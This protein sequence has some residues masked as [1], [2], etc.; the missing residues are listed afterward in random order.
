MQTIEIIQRFEAKFAKP[1]CAGCPDGKFEDTIE[2]WATALAEQL[3]H[4]TGAQWGILTNTVTGAGLVERV[5]DGV[6]VHPWFIVDHPVEGKT[7]EYSEQL[8]SERRGGADMP[9]VSWVIPANH[10]HDQDRD[11]IAE[12]LDRLARIE[13]AQADNDRKA[14]LRNLSTAGMVQRL[15]VLVTHYGTAPVLLEFSLFGKTF[16]FTLRN[17]QAEEGLRK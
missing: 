8:V 11:R 17:P 3:A 1:V 12:I 10:L 7:I 2:K 9:G 15:L 14:H 4:E 13:S 6:R 16:T 5:G